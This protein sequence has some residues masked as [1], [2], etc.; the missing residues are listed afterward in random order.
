MII[1]SRVVEFLDLSSSTKRCDFIPKQKIWYKYRANIYPTYIFS[2][3]LI[4][5]V[6]FPATTKRA[7]RSRSATLTDGK[8]IHRE[9]SGIRE[10]KGSERKGRMEDLEALRKQIATTEVQL[11]ELKHQLAALEERDATTS[12]TED[13]GG[14]LETEKDLSGIP[15]GSKWPLSPEEYM[16]YGR[17]MIVPQVGIQGMDTCPPCLLL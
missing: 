1:K 3:S 7:S 10:R 17:Q 14:L 12:T 16:R 5:T 13:G 4:F 11:T 2:N 6:A 8:E 9:E 15:N